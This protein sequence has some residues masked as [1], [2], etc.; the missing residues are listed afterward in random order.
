MISWP[1]YIHKTLQPPDFQTH[2]NYI[3]CLE[4]MSEG[5]SVSCNITSKNI[6][7]ESKNLKNKL[8]L[9]KLTYKSLKYEMTIIDS[10]NEFAEVCVPWVAVKTYYMLFN[11]MLILV[12]LTCGREDTFNLT[13]D[14]TI[15][16]I[17]GHIKNNNLRFSNNDFNINYNC[18]KVHNFKFTAGY[19]VKYSGYEISTRYAQLMK[20]L[21]KYKIES[22]KRSQRIK[23]FKK[24]TNRAGLK[25]Y[26]ENNDIN[27]IDFFYLYRLKA[28]YRDLEFLDKEINA[29]QYREFYKSYYNL[30]IAFY[31]AFKHCINDMSIKRLGKRIIADES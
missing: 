22:Y 21:C 24:K 1:T 9:V 30:T 18:A 11:M 20:K 5:L 27:V 7:G 29:I 26:L 19:N 10:N 31:N 15:N 6:I 25:V 4:S 8:T 13:H 23:D 17:K 16:I 14:K 28:N 2:L 3:Q 12:Y